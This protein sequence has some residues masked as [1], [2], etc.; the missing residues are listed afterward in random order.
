VKL[1]NSIG[2]KTY[3]IRQFRLA[4]IAFYAKM[5]DK[6]QNMQKYAGKRKKCEVCGKLQKTR[7]FA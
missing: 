1:S 3:G 5:C 6:R 4:K 2:D 7:F